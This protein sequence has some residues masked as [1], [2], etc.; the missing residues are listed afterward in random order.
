MVKKIL[1]NYWPFLVIFIVIFAFFARLFFPPSIFVTPDFGRTDIL[2]IELPQKYIL[3]SSLKHLSLPFWETDS[4]Q[5]Y[6]LFAE[7]AGT[8]NITNLV[9]LFLLPFNIAI[10]IIYLL[11]F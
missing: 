11:T 3:S 4:G 1:T 5:G 10:P 8:F 6:P 9:S 2:H 7:L